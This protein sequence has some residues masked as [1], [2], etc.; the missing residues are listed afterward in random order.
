MPSGMD[1]RNDCQGA[2]QRG[3][4]SAAKN[5]QVARQLPCAVLT[6]LLFLLSVLTTAFAI[7]CQ[8]RVFL[9]TMRGHLMMSG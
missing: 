5:C 4:I 1:L 9:G 8:F 6:V 7:L 2:N 3:R